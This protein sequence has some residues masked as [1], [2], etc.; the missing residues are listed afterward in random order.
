MKWVQLLIFGT[1]GLALLLVGISWG[2]EAY[3]ICRDN[4]FTSGTV[5]DLYADRSG[6]TSDA[7][8]LPVIEFTIRNNTKVRFRADAGTI[9]PAEFEKGSTI[10]VLYDPNNP[11]N[12]RIGSYTQLW[13][14]PLIAGAMGLLITL[15]SLLLFIKIG[16]FERALGA[17]GSDSKS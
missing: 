16:R 13:R 4:V 15:L 14:G 2:L 10:N 5:V 8:V 9:N 7:V 3:P 17:L 12:A 11:S 1:S 6:N